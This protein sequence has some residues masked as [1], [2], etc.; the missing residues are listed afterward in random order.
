[1]PFIVHGRTEKHDDYSWL[2]IDNEKAFVEA[3]KFLV[4]LGHRKIALL[5]GDLRMNYAWLRREG[6]VKAMQQAGLEI[7][8]DYLVDNI[9]DEI[10]ARAA[11]TKLLELPVRPTA[12]VCVTDAVA[13]GAIHA[14]GGAGLQV[15]REVSVIGYDGL[16]MGAAIEPALTTMSQASHEAG[17]QVG[18]MLLAQAQSKSSEISQIL[19]EAKLT[20]RASANPPVDD[21]ANP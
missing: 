10:T 12:V 13:I 5:G 18:R 9:V 19:W 21:P 2:D 6:F 16:P 3:V 15:G 4:G 14:I 11:M 20:L 7:A 17:R 1:V 8:P